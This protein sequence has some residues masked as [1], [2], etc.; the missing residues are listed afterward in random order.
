MA[1]V[2]MNRREL[3]L[4]LPAALVFSRYAWS[5]SK[6][7][8]CDIAII[9]GGT[10]GY[11]AALAALRNGMRVILTEETDWLGG[12]LTAQAVPPDEHPWIEKFGSTASYRQYRQD[13]RN[14]YRKN[15]PLTAEARSNPY[16]NPGNG[17][18]SRLTHEFG[19]S[20]KVLEA[21][22]HP[23]IASG[24]L[25]VL[26]HHVPESA[27]TRGDFIDSVTV[28]DLRT[29]ARHVLHAR[30][31]LD[32]TELGDL[33]AMAE[34]ESI[35][36]AEAQSTTQEMSAP[37]VAQPDHS[38][39]VA[40]CFAM[41]YLEGED[42][43]IEKP[44]HY[45]RWKDYCPQLV[46]AWT[47]RL[48]SWTSCTPSTLRPQTAEM[49]PNGTVSK[50]LNDLWSFRRIADRKNFTAGTY[51]SDITLVN[52]PQNDFW[53]Q[54]LVTA[55]PVEQ[56]KIIAQARELSLSL[57]YWMQTEAPR[58]DG[59]TGFRGLRLRPDITGTSDGLAKSV[60]VR[61]SRRIQAEFTILQQHVDADVRR[62]LFQ[63]S[64]RARRAE[65][66]PDSVGVGCYRI[67]LHPSV[68][69]VNYIDRSCLPFQIPLG[70]LLPIRVQNLIP[71]CK[72]IGTTHISNGCTRLHPVEWN[73]GE[74]AGALVSFALSRQRLPR[75]VRNRPALL[76]DFQRSL[77]AQGF[78]L[79]WPRDVHAI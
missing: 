4:A 20:A 22:L 28:R 5:G 67:D 35:T 1:G 25:T 23:Y 61:E 10:G 14:Y 7:L 37:S 15:F 79:E 44:A 53:L 72:N 13:V 52:W 12:Q 43:T 57:F 65:V 71:A 17:S 33:L 75:E 58:P 68:G 69:G 64:D 6:E 2:S 66:Y 50:G 48:L 3:V 60:Y 19:V 63:D 62:M 8:R 11:A 21:K 55:T 78:E 54:D 46:P 59:G 38:Q 27:A 18:V 74:A 76:L 70:A 39:G 56:T 47:G 49:A 40:Y 45:E 42:H 31:F 30:Y 77:V 26:Y 16:L 9:G 34:A 51:R 32:A 73:I 41:E 24:K 36:G 29:E